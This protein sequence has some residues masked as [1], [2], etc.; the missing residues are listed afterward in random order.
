[1]EDGVA[2]CDGECHSVDGGGDET[3]VFDLAGPLIGGDFGD[4]FALGV[5]VDGGWGAGMGE[6]EVDDRGGCGEVDDRLGAESEP[7]D[8]VALDHLGSVCVCDFDRHL[9]GAAG[10]RAGSGHSWEKLHRRRPL[11]R[12][13][14]ILPVDE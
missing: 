4:P 9:A 5:G 2:V 10:V 3:E 1:L 7:A 13:P 6:A 11:T 8:S 14:L 12:C